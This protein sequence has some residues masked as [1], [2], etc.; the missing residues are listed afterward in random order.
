VLTV[1]YGPFQPALERAFLA[2]LKKAKQA[3]ALAPLC[4]VTPSRAIANRLERLITREEA[5][6][7]L[8]VTFHTFYSIAHEIV[9]E[10]EGL[11]GR[12]LV[13]DP[14]FFDRILNNFLPASV[15]MKSLRPRGV[16]SSYR[17]SLK[18][19]MDAGVG[20]G[21]QLLLE[22]GLLAK[23]E[24]ANHL[25]ELLKILKNF[26]HYLE[27]IRVVP[28]SGLTQRATEL[29]ASS[30]YLKRYKLFFLLRFL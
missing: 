20:E 2:E 16:A 27:A 21:A 15:V 25:R 22:E 4:I 17:A 7:A 28:P 1:Q 12:R 11:P 29:V 14:M 13:R 6:A 18:D 23:Q 8:Q 24:E 10:D 26:T 5:F 3:D 19:L 9:K 30:Q